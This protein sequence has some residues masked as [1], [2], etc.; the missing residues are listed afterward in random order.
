MDTCTSFAAKVQATRLSPVP[1]AARRT[2][3]AAAAVASARRQLAGSA[4]CRQ[5]K[6]E[7]PTPG[8]LAQH[9]RRA[10][11][12]WTEQP[13]PYAWCCVSLSTDASLAGS[14]AGSAAPPWRL[15]RAAAKTLL[16]E[17]H[18]CPID[19]SA[20]H[21]SKLHSTLA[22]QQNYN[23]LFNCAWLLTIK[24]LER[25]LALLCTSSIYI[26]GAPGRSTQPHPCSTQSGL[27]IERLNRP[28]L[29]PREREH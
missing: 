26:C 21:S 14:A 18:S 1:P 22:R 28:Q 7:G 10:C 11:A 23:P 13:R 15:T 17:T 4:K 16:R 12:S 3:P 8:P 25:R 20:R 6:P 27:L 29:P 9:I 5:Q 19:L 2:P 24:V